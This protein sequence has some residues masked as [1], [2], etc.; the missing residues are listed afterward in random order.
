MFSLLYYY[1]L[2]ISAAAIPCNLREAEY[3]YVCVCNSTYCD[4]LPQLN[5]ELTSGYYQLITS[6]EA[7]LRFEISNGSFTDDLS[8][9]LYYIN[10]DRSTTYQTILGYGGAFTD[11]TGINIAALSNSSQEYLLRSYFSEDGSEY[12]FGRVP[13]GGADFSARGYTYDDG[14]NGTLEGFA[15]EYEDYDYKVGKSFRKSK[16]TH[17]FSLISV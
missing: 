13:V 16:H 5:D 3:G 9:S 7:G 6:N 1:Q 4:T 12:T 11:S 8:L 15:L 10:V 14:G 2:N 17:W